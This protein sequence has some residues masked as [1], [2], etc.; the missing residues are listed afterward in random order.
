MIRYDEKLNNKINRVVKNYNA[1]IRR[2]EK[3][4]KENVYIPKKIDKSVLNSL[5]ESVNTRVDLNRRIKDLE[6]F[7][8][9]GGEEYVKGTHTPRYINNN[10][11]RYK[12]ILNYNIKKEQNRIRDQYIKDNRNLDYLIFDMDYKN[13]EAKKKMADV[14]I[15]GRSIED[16]N[17]YLNKLKSNTREIDFEQWQSNYM[18][19]LLDTGYMYGLDSH[20]LQKLRRKLETLDAREFDKLYKNEK[21]INQI[22]YY[23]KQITDIAITY[24]YNEMESDIVGLYDELFNNIDEIIKDYE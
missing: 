5:K 4:N 3:L 22:L 6:E 15:K 13:L 24:T 11:K 20:K 7:N 14:N 18:D 16:L 2:L 1:K 23:Y 12:R 8:K 21:I 19:M 17:T 10:I 9:R